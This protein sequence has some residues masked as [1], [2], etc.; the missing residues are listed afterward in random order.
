MSTPNIDSLKKDQILLEFHKHSLMCEKTGKSENPSTPLLAL[1]E[2]RLTALGLLGGV[3]DVPSEKAETIA[4]MVYTSTVI[5]L[6]EEMIPVFYELRKK[7]KEAYAACT[8][9]PSQK[10]LP[11]DLIWFRSP[12]S[13]KDEERRETYQA[14][15]FIQDSTNAWITNLHA[16]AL[17]FDLANAKVLPAKRTQYSTDAMAILLEEKIGALNEERPNRQFRKEAKRLGLRHDESVRVLTLRTIDRQG[18]GS[19]DS[20]ATKQYHHRWL[21]RGHIR[22]QWFASRQQHELVWIDP[23]EKGPE[24]APFKETVRHVV[25]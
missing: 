10:K 16:D 3:F 13:F 1:G 6:A 22:N 20:N 23:H 9:L 24:G 7:V 17:C 14:Q 4:E 19:S 12:Y 8:T 21:V 5:F 2:K 18:G 25:R 15:L 11:F